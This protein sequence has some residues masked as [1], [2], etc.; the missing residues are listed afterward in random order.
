MATLEVWERSACQ[1]V[2][3]DGERLVVGTSTD[4][5]LVLDGDRSVSRLHMLLERLGESW[6]VR[7]LDS[8]N[9]TLVNGH[10]LFRERPL[11][12]GDE[13]LI[14]RTRI[15]FRHRG[16]RRTNATESLADRPTITRRERDVLVALCRP[17]LA[18][19]VFTEPAL[20]KDIA[21]AMGV[22]QAAVKQHL[23][24]LYD[25]F[26]VYDGEDSSKRSRLANAA[27]GCG[28]VTLDDLQPRRS[29]SG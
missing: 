15:V 4:A 10:P 18:G 1:V 13:L 17:V 11:H 20:V 24:H 23:G 28:A 12:D 5:D 25:K 21:D 2:V 16:E 7:D 9:G 22:T 3:L 27:L 14:G 19:S 26:G 8:R 6:C 29:D